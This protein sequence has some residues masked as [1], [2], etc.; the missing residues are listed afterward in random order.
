MDGRGF[1]RTPGADDKRG[2]AWVPDA[3]GKRAA[4]I[5][6]DVVPPRENVRVCAECGRKWVRVAFRGAPTT[7]LV[8]SAISVFRNGWGVGGM[9]CRWGKW[10]DFYP[11]AGR[12]R[13]IRV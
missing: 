12:G 9:P 1:A 6:E 5:V 10:C 7:R 2:E 3:T 4:H 8:L 13:V 11:A